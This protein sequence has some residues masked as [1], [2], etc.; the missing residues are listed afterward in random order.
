MAIASKTLPTPPSWTMEHPAQEVEGAPVA[1]VDETAAMMMP[2]AAADET[3]VRPMPGAAEDE[4]EER[5][6]LVALA[7]PPLSVPAMACGNSRRQPDPPERSAPPVTLSKLSSWSASL[8][9]RKPE[10]LG[11]PA[12]S[13]LRQASRH[14]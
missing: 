11:E 1:A 14:A 9:R 3:V 10:M 4:K 12:A 5:P 6:T 8:T 7:V 13:A 2:G